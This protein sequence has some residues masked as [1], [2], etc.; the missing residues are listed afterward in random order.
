MNTI[1]F[2]ASGPVDLA[3]AGAEGRTPAPSKRSIN[4]LF[5]GCAVNRV[6][7]SAIVGPT[8]GTSRTS[9]KLACIKRSSVPACAARTSA[10]WA[11]T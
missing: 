3:G 5:S 9:S 6:M 11:P 1:C 7:L 8:P 4:R 2:P 10:T